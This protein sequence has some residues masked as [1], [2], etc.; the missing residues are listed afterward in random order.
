MTHPEDLKGGPILDRD[1]SNSNVGSVFTPH[2]DLMEVVELRNG[3]RNVLLLLRDTILGDE[4]TTSPCMRL[5][6]R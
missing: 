5:C 6:L 4:F 1:G 3:E 2:N